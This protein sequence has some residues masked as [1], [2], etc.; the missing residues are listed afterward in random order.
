MNFESL[1]NVLIF[2]KFET[3]AKQKTNTKLYRKFGISNPKVIKYIT[4]TQW[5]RV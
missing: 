4:N 2:R 3:F 5:S 1:E